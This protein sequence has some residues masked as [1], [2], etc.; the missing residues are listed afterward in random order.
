MPQYT[1]GTRTVWP[2]ESVVR[3][4]VRLLAA[5][6]YAELE[7][8]SAGTRLT[9][10]EIAAAA[11]EYPYRIAEPPAGAAP[12]LDVVRILAAEPPAWSVDVPLWTAEAGRSDLTLQL[13][14][15]AWPAGTYAVEIDDLHV[16]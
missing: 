15:R 13:T 16:L 5:G 6:D 9:A 10:G 1:E 4:L 14:V 8:R 11:A 3:D 2:F 12:P 7:R